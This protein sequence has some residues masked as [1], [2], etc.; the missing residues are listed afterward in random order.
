M[1]ARHILLYSMGAL[2]LMT[3]CQNNDNDGQDGWNGEIRLQAVQQGSTRAVTNVQST[4]FCEGQEVAVFINEHDQDPDAANKTDYPQPLV[5]TVSD[6]EGTLTISNAE[7]PV[8]PHNSAHGIDVYATYPSSVVGVGTFTVRPQQVLADDYMAS[9]LMYGVAP[10]DVRRTATVVPLSFT[11]QLTKFVVRLEAASG[12]SL[13]KGA[14]VELLGIKPSVPITACN[15]TGMT[16]GEA[17]GEATD[18]LMTD[19]YNNDT[20]QPEAN[21]GCAAVIV[22]QEKGKG[23]LI[24]ITLLDG[25]QRTFRLREAMTFESGKVYTYVISLYMS[26]L[27]LRCEVTPW[28]D[29]DQPMNGTFMVE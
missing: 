20:E 3:A 12:S 4:Q 19:N 17:T 25:T 22:P 11:H 13:F 14:T 5:F 26:S 1:K 21:E 27:S 6:D 29:S 2:L 24:R 10:E 16:L 7:A 9:D 18:I 8:F 23:E 15:M 28:T